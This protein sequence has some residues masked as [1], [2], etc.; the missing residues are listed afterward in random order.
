MLKSSTTTTC[1]TPMC[2]VDLG[3][4]SWGRNFGPRVWSRWSHSAPMT[5]QVQSACCS[6]KDPWLKWGYVY[7]KIVVY[8]Y[9]Y[10]ICDSMCMFVPTGWKPNQRFACFYVFHGVNGVGWGGV[11][12]NVHLHCLTYMMLR[13]C[14]SFC[15]SSHAWCYAAVRLLAR[16]HIHDATLLYVVLHFLTYMMLR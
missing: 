4:A 15:T 11:G 10:D 9:I 8:I 16:P 1:W 3:C 14:T 12:N 13:C 7:V 5:L 6:L 2:S